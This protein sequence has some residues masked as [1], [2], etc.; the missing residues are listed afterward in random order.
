[1]VGLAEG[2]AIGNSSRVK[3]PSKEYAVARKRG[4]L[5]LV[6]LLC[7]VG[8][9]FAPRRIELPALG[10]RAESAT[11]SA[12][13][14]GQEPPDGA[15]RCESDK[16]CDDGIACTRDVCLPS[17]F[18]RNTGDNAR[19]SDGI[20]C[21]GYEICD[22]R[23]G[24]HASEVALCDDG[25]T[26]TIDSCDEAQQSCVHAPRDLDRDG[27]VDA[28]CPGGT[29]CNDFDPTTGL[30]QPELCADHIDNNCNGVVDETP[31]QR[32]QH[33]TCADPLDVSAGGRFVLPLTGA[34]SDYLVS[35]DA[36]PSRDVVFSFELAAPRSVKLVAH[37]ALA[38]GTD[39]IATLALQAQCGDRSTELACRQGFPGDLRVRS[40]DSGRY[41]VVASSFSAATLVLDVSLADPTVA[42]ANTSCA[43]ALDVSAGGR[44][45]GDFVGVADVITS[46]CSG[47]GQPDLFYAFTLREPRDVEVSAISDE[48]GRLTMSLRDGCSQDAASLRCRSAEPV[49]THLHQLPA[50][51]YVLVLEGP[52]SREVSFALDVA[53]LAPTPPPAGSVCANPLPIA[54]GKQKTTVTL[55]D[56]QEVF[57]TSCGGRADHAVFALH[58][59]DATDLDLQLDAGDA[60]VTVVLESS[61]GDKLS[62]LGCRTGAPA[63]TR[64][65]NV[66][67]GDYF[68]VVG[69]PSAHSVSLGID[70]ADLTQPTAAVGNSGCTNAAEVPGDG[71][72]FSGD[73][74]GMPDTYHAPC[75]G[76][77]LSPDAVFRLVLSAPKHVVA[78]I[79]ASF[80]SVLYRFRDSRATPDVCSGSSAEACDDDSG[81]N[82]QA[83]LDEKLDAD[84]YYFVVDGFKDY[85][86]G[87][88]SFELV[89]SDQ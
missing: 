47:P 12:A 16:T 73:T 40:L 56:P 77:A 20:F 61:C 25:D 88:Y 31:C 85:S 81:P 76:G 37:G 22:P 8:C 82:A 71:G 74:T 29:D 35:C 32:P 66:L 89:I 28:H 79:D 36:T 34:S 11:G 65:R 30:H 72:V 52:S 33:D 68:V 43:A 70:A 48:G 55:T 44:F 38:D 64:M 58:V 2:G 87:P 1:M 3:T 60:P 18:C 21:D 26:C 19:C 80:D 53:F 13:D 49:Q 50:G 5:A 59:S 45:A 83:V 14:A 24:C 6:W 51:S 78:K 86:S 42:P 54:L 46:S 23:S 67:P 41:Y 15:I 4:A 75:G 84:T 63:A 7:A 27:E 62:E 17:G 39:E 69:S 57:D 9:D 10:P